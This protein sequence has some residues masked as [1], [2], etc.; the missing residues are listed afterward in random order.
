MKLFLPA[1]A[2]LPLAVLSDSPTLRFEEGASLRQEWTV[3]TE[4]SVLSSTLRIMGNDQDIGAGL[5]VVRE[6]A[7]IAVDR[8][9]KAED[10]ALRALTRSY[11]SIVDRTDYDGADEV[12]GAVFKGAGSKESLLN[13]LDVVFAL[14]DDAEEFAA[15]FAKGSEGDE[16][17]LEGVRVEAH[18]EWLVPEDEVSEGDSWEVDPGS[19]ASLLEPLSGS[20]VEEAPEAPDGPEGGIAISAPS[21]DER[22]DPAAMEGEITARWASTDTDEGA[23]LATIE[24]TVELEATVDLIPEFND[25]ASERGADEEYQVAEYERTLAGE[26][27]VVWDLER[28]VPVSVAGELEGTA[29]YEVEWTLNAQSMELELAASGEAE[30]TIQI[31]AA[32]SVE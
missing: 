11:E 9:D 14:D 6:S 13:G 16:D 12:E 10:G 25:D 29:A 4:K 22:F 20:M 15:S 8:L 27:T 30:D 21:P 7:R 18:L 5:T 32:F 31:E 2:L 23:R 3:R 1:A 28:D 19:I 26:L 17:W 24:L